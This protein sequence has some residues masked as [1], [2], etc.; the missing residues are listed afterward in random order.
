ML[1]RA[2]ILAVQQLSDP[3]IL[4]VLLKSVVIT[5]LFFVAIGAALW[6]VLEPML[7]RWTASIADESYGALIALFA[8]GIIALGGAWLL[9]RVVALAVIQFFADDV[10]RAVER[11]HYGDLADVPG[12]P[13]KTE[14]RHSLRSALRTIGVNLLVAPLALLLLFTGIG[15]ALVFWIANA[16]LLGR[17]L[18]DMVWLRHQAHDHSAIPIGGLDRFALGGLTAALLAIPGLNLIA[19]IIG[20][21]SAT[22]LIHQRKHSHAPI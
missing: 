12:L 21:A 7:A 19:P 17:E 18:Q 2:L 15:T 14:L 13:F 1:V 3:A 8:S 22:H 10:V 6:W 16:F 5:L 4:K 9:F 11:K 20:A